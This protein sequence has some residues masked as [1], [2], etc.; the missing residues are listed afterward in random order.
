VL[1]P[2]GGDEMPKK[3]LFGGFGK[4]SN[5]AAA[6]LSGSARGC[7]GL[8]TA[9]MKFQVGHRLHPLHFWHDFEAEGRGDHPS[10]SLCADADLHPA[11]WAD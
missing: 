1:T 4:K 7:R 11:L 10:Q 3:S 5:G 2:I 8:G 9:P 6:T